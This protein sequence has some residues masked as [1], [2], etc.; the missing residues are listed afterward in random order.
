MRIGIDYLPAVSHAPGVGR[1][2]RELVRAVLQLADGPDLALLEVGRATRSIFEPALG[3]VGAGARV[4]RVKS[5]L[6]R[7]AV[8]WL[9]PLLCRHADRWLGGVDVFQHVVLPT[10]PV[11]RA[12]QCLALAELP[13]E[14]SQA[15]ARLRHTLAKIDGVLVF[16][17]DFK[18]RIMS[19]YGLAST[20]VHRT[21]VGCDHWRRELV[22]RPEPTS[23]P[24]VLV[25][26]A[27]RPA[28]RHLAILRAVEVLDARKVEVKLV[29]VGRAGPAADE[30]KRAVSSSPVRDRVTWREDAVESELPRIVGAASVLVHLSDDEGT[31]VTPLEAF[32]LGVA[33]VAS[34]LP[35]FQESLGGLATWIE[36]ETAVRE[37]ARL[38]DALE[39]GLASAAEPAHRDACELHARNFPWRACAQA[40]V[41][42][43]RRVAGSA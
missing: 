9:A 13:P 27:L 11:L 38:A 35:A 43:W 41:E 14:G 39:L 26:G 30:W 31:A 17:A 21:P 12:P 2:T 4:T 16:S 29:F 22:A 19:R 28:R 18:E 24:T 20:Q 5:A 23:P 3:L 25:L 37:P 6:P 8:P 10:L 40:T 1:Y 36:N 7:R 32:A 42:V 33:V 34:P 15:D